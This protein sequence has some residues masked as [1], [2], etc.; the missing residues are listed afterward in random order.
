METTAC[1]SSWSQ[2]KNC[3]SGAKHF[4]HFS[5]I[6]VIG[7]VALAELY[8]FCHHVYNL[9]ESCACQGHSFPIFFSVNRHRFLCLEKNLINSHVIRDSMFILFVAVAIYRLMCLINRWAIWLFAIYVL[10]EKVCLPSAI[11][12]VRCKLPA[13][14]VTCG[15]V[16]CSHAKN[17]L[18]I[19]PSVPLLIDNQFLRVCEYKTGAQ[20]IYWWAGRKDGAVFRFQCVRHEGVRLLC[21]SYCFLMKHSFIC[22]VQ[23]LHRQF[24]PTIFPWKKL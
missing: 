21:T 22:I 24:R 18:N 20:K 12:A 9:E 14:D 10:Y 23:F 3:V 2:L 8:I 7:W 13:M 11:R 15:D 19:F 4:W 6:H 1:A 5:E 16:S 17:L